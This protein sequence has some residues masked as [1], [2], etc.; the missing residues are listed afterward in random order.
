MFYCPS[1]LHPKDLLIETLVK[2]V[3]TAT[4]NAKKAQQDNYFATRENRLLAAGEL[5]NASESANEIVEQA[6]RIVLTFPYR[7]FSEYACGLANGT[8]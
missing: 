5:A 7:D 1:A 4:N 3:Q 2:V 8:P 6:K